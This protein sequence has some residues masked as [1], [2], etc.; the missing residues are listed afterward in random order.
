MAIDT[1]VK[2]RS[3]AGVP[4]IPLGPGVTPNSDKDL[5]WRQQA[6]WGYSGIEVA[7]VAEIIVQLGIAQETNTA[8]P[9]SSLVDVLQSLGIATETD[10]VFAIFSPSVISWQDVED[11][12]IESWSEVNSSDTQV[13]EDV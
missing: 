3:T 1:A 5:A 12:D 13:W 11:S 8:F 4:F 2:R 9:I 6:A 7:T 10:A